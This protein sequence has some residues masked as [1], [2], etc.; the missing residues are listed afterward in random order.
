MKFD[1][2]REI[3]ITKPVLNELLEC[4][5]R[6]LNDFS[7]S[8]PVDNAFVKFYN[9]LRLEIHPKMLVITFRLKMPGKLISHATS[10]V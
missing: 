1:V 2:V 5:R 8:D 3:E 4:T 10:V 6:C 9:L 7:S